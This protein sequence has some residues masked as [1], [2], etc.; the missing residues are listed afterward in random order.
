[1]L[2]TKRLLNSLCL[3]A[4]IASSGMGLVEA[5]E[6]GEAVTFDLQT[7]KLDDLQL[8]MNS[9]VPPASSW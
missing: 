6:I 3:S 7:A 5:A 8:A 1:M 4:L 2:K 9:K